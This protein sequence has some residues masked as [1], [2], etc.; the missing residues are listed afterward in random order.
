MP[1]RACSTIDFRKSPRSIRV[2]LFLLFYALTPVLSAQITHTSTADSTPDYL[3][4]S[5]AVR[6]ADPADLFAG[7]DDGLTARTEYAIRVMEPRTG[8]MNIFGARLLREFRVSYEIRYDPFRRRYTLTT[9]DGGLYTFRDTDSLW[10]FFF[11]L[12]EYRIP[13]EAVEPSIRS[14]DASLMIETRVTYSPIVFVPGLSILSIL[15]PDSAQQSGWVRREIEV[16]R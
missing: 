6:G 15:L 5:I 10:S 4:V 14:A 11:S 13:W 16:A 3:E 1:S 8:P 2:A 12:P 7:L 9:H